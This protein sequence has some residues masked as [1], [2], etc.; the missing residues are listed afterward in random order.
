MSE[1]IIEIPSEQ[2]TPHNEKKITKIVC[3]PKLKYVATWSD[4]DMSACIYSIEDQMNPEFEKCYSLKEQVE[5]G[6]S[7]EM[8]NDFLKAK[9]YELKLSDQ[10]HIVLMPY[11]KGYRHAALFTLEHTLKHYEVK[12]L[13]P[14]DNKKEIIESNFIV[15]EGDY[16]LLIRGEKNYKKNDSTNSIT[17]YIFELC[18][19]LK[20]MFR[21]S[22]Y[23]YS[24]DHIVLHNNGY[25]FIYKHDTHIIMAWNTIT[26]ES[27]AYLTTEWEINCIRNIVINEEATLLAIWINNFIYIYSIKFQLMISIHNVGYN[28]IKCHFISFEDREWLLVIC[29]QKHFYLL[30]PY[31][32]TEKRNKETEEISELEL[33]QLYLIKYSM[34][35]Y[36][37]ENKLKVQKFPKSW[38]YK[39]NNVNSNLV[40]TEVFEEI[41]KDDESIPYQLDDKWDIKNHQNKVI[42]SYNNVDSVKTDIPYSGVNNV[43]SVKIDIPYTGIKRI[44]LL[45]NK[46]LLMS[47]RDEHEDCPSGNIY[48]WTIANVKEIPKIR[49]SYF[50]SSSTSFQKEY[51][52]YL[53]YLPP[54]EFEIELKIEKHETIH[55]LNELIIEDYAN[56][57]FKLSLYG[58][59]LM[60]HLL[61]NEKFE[62]IEMLLKNI[63]NLTIKNSDKSFISN[64]PLVKIVTYNFRALSHYSEII[65]WFLCKIAFFVPDD[66]L[67]EIISTNST[68]NHLQKFGEYP[69]IFDISLIYLKIESFLNLVVTNFKHFKHLLKFVI[70]LPKFSPHKRKKKTVKLVFPLMGLTDYSIGSYLMRKLD[71]EYNIME[72][73]FIVFIDTLFDAYSSFGFSPETNLYELWIGE[74][75]L[76]YKW[77]TYGRAIHITTLIIHIF[78]LICFVLT[79]ISYDQIRPFIRLFILSIVIVITFIDYI[80]DLIYL[81]YESRMRKIDILFFTA[82]TIATYFMLFA[83]STII[84]YK[85]SKSYSGW[86]YSI[87]NNYLN[88]SAYITFAILLLELKILLNIHTFEFFGTEFAIIFGVFNEV[89]PFIVT[90]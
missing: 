86:F 89:L 80:L 87:D 36:I 59:R 75:L 14:K 33:N 47:M 78:C 28:I 63:I 24:K 42:L 74:A 72:K 70:P 54:P 5:H 6:L 20:K 7:E 11:N 79:V 88:L 40:A 82:D 3:S 46:D 18:G 55:E 68:S 53:P 48:I 35:F 71:F 34:V 85:D 19:K 9:K 56:S 44:K 77:N 12:I 17:G 22:K 60:E 2:S 32:F 15:N 31:I 13:E 4:E 1:Q 84:Y 29:K 10:K 65:N 90:L 62:F 26:L 23:N 37:D 51:K 66:T 16:Y 64:L 61:E 83:A 49:L 73:K 57:R 30:D 45:K 69:N 39:L 58:R 67:S 81:I 38:M 8:K 50:W 43:D 76:T 21:I 25:I 41:E 27:I 52:E